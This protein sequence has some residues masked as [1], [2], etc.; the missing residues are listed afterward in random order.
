MKALIVIDFTNDFVDGSLP[1]GEP[2]IAIQHRIAELTATCSD[3]GDYV[4]M[5]VD[6]HEENDPYHPETKLF[7]PHNIRGT[8]GRELYGAL[9]EVYDQRQSSIYW[10]DK[11]R[12]SAFSGTDLHHKL[13]ERGITEVHLVGVCTDICVLHTAVDAYNLGYAITV[14][15]DAVASFNSDGHAWALGHFESS[16]GA[17]VVRSGDNR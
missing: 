5:A 2:A 11:T 12:Y 10:M 6:L 15:E 17:T 9:Q 1:V 4:V 7:P 3:R 14:Y 16:L 13:R 8:S